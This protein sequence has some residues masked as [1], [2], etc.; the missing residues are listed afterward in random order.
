MR[1]ETQRFLGAVADAIDAA[2]DPHDAERRRF[3]RDVL[4]PMV[5]R[6]VG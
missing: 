2:E 1:R 5:E 3:A 6:A 4:T